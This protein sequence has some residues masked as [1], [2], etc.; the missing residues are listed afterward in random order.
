MR[1]MGWPGLLVA[2]A[3]ALLTGTASGQRNSC[4]EVS[5]ALFAGSNYTFVAEGK[6][7]RATHAVIKFDFNAVVV[8][9]T[10]DVDNGEAAFADNTVVFVVPDMGTNPT[11][12]TA[13]LDTC[14]ATEGAEIVSTWSYA[15]AEGNNLDETAFDNTGVVPTF[16][17]ESFGLSIDP[18]VH[19][20]VSVPVVDICLH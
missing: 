12:F 16:C 9:A 1:T 7:C 2:T 20:F 3:F 4:I 8:D 13:V 14:G 17:C 15:D 11:H 10:V 6:T 18:V 19:S 5:D